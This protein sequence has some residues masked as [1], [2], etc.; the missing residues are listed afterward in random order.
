MAEFILKTNY[1]MPN[2]IRGRFWYKSSAKENY[3]AKSIF[4]WFICEQVF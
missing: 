2:Y 3:P 1:P 4:D